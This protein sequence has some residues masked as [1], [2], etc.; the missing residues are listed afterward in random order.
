MVKKLLE[1]CKYIAEKLGR[2]AGGRKKR[3][4]IIL[5]MFRDILQK[6][7]NFFNFL[8]EIIL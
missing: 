6:S 1:D 7:Y 2:N 3:A 8:V 5:G 4:Q